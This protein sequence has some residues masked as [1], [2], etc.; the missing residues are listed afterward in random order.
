[1]TDSST[2]I[3]AVCAGDIT[4]VTGFLSIEP[5][6]AQS[7]NASGVSALLL[8]LYHGHDRLAKVLEQR[9][10]RLDIFEAAALGEVEQVQ[11]FLSADPALADA[12]T[13]DGFDALGLAAHFGQEAAVALL[14]R[15]SDPNR[16]SENALQVTAL[17]AAV[18]CRVR[19][20]ALP[21]A[22]MLLAHGANPNLRQQ[23]GW[24]AL[25]GAAASGQ[26]SLVKLLLE[27]GADPSIPDDEGLCAADRARKSGHEALA[28]TIPVG[29]G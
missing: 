6:L 16:A 2:L 23:R 10:P 3:E 27:H 11:R 12:R 20:K 5:M 18:A 15:W 1:M 28:A 26:S 29:S 24:T 13:A 14:V 17:H 8:A 25:H 22:R 9:L 7:R 21:L 4:A 19:D